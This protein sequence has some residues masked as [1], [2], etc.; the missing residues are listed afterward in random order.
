ML[1]VKALEEADRLTQENE[2][3]AKEAEQLR[4]D[5]FGDVEEK[6]KQ[7]DSYSSFTRGVL[8]RCYGLQ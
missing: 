7:H 8:A 4:S 5:K 6:A 2:K 1:Q 3:L